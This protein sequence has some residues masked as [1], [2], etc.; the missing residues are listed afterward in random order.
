MAP[1]VFLGLAARTAFALAMAA[2]GSGAAGLA[3]V[4][5]IV[6]LLTDLQTRIKN[7]H[8]TEKQVYD[9]FACWCEK[10]SSRKATAIEE[11]Q[12]D[13]RAL[14]QSVLKLRGTV[15]V[16]TAEMAQLK[17]EMDANQEQQAELTAI[18]QREN[19]AYVAETTE[20]KE[21]LA[22]LQKAIVVLR[23]ATTLLQQ[24]GG[25]SV[26]T[27]TAAVRAVMQ[28]LPTT[29]RLKPDQLAVLTQLASAGGAKYS[30]QS[31]TVQGILQ[32]MY[33]TFSSDLESATKTEA[34]ANRQF[35][36]M[37]AQ[38]TDAFKLLESTHAK[39]AGEKAEAEALLAET[40]QSY[41]DTEAQ[42]H[43]DIKFFDETKA[44][45]EAKNAEW[46]TRSQLRAEELKGIGEALTILTS[47]AAREL[48]HSAI[49]AGKETGASDAYDAGVSI[50]FLQVSGDSA[51]A[52]GLRPAALGAYAALKS[53]ATEAHSLRLAV[54]A[55]QVREAKVGHFDKV[56][57]AI[58]SMVE[59]LKAEDAADIAK[60]DQC[61]E[62]YK[63]IDSTVGQVTWLIEKNVAKIDKLEGLIAARTA[64]KAATIEEIGRVTQEIKDMTA[65]RQEENA[66]F[67]HAKAEDQA[68]IA[69]LVEA[70]SAL[71]A[72]YSNHTIE[73]GPIQGEK[74]GLALVS[75]HAE[76]V[77]EVSADDAPE[78][79]FAG[80]GSRKHETKGIVQIMTMLIE[81]L[82][83]EI[84]NGMKDEESAQLKYEELLGSAQALKASLEAKELS[85]QQT[86]AFLGGE[87]ADEHAA[88][89]GNQAD[90]K[91][92]L[93][94]KADIKTDC[95]WIMA[96]FTERATRRQAELKGLTEAKAYLAGYDKASLLEQR[97]PAFDD[98]VLPRIGFLGLG[99]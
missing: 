66:A 42:M 69:L 53:K 99:R 57:A 20:M 74:K 56:I 43:A 84:R 27:A 90:L 18:R 58:D 63:N 54:L 79:I 75:L 3:P 9:K 48:F 61:I 29:T 96:A 71:S 93:A 88:K 81:D 38:L 26:S 10:A 59:T 8:E 30:P 32:D 21:A 52:R 49:K 41:D 4:E 83:D 78:A 68:A 62:E 17:K 1:L 16:R 82:N 37:I 24:G 13:L 50:A 11:A 39:K 67:K 77:F 46:T 36:T 34:N 60:R 6:H 80:D 51:S 70:R 31:W 65:Q 89:S 87:K 72:Y 86:I 5:K 22:A 12:E 94:Y 15:A 40:S 92:E 76:P 23:D 28:A 55:A 7:D 95:D 73:L 47:D 2:S 14:G 25:A 91:D 33:A 64:E 19:A 35:E 45:C 98:S 97:R 44:S 85:L